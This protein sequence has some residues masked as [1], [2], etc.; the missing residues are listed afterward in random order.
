[1]SWRM[2]ADKVVGQRGP[3]TFEQKLSDR[4]ESGHEAPLGKESRLMGAHMSF[5]AN[6]KLLRSS[7][8][9]SVVNK[10]D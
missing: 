1:M 7:R 4:V 2:T 5:Q 6:N 8:H 3:V 10:S 9:G